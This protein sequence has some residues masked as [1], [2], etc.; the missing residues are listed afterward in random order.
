MRELKFRVWDSTDKVMDYEPYFTT[1]SL[2]ANFN[3]TNLIFM[4]WTGLTDRQGVEIYEGDIVNDND[5]YWYVVEYLAGSFCGKPVH[6]PG[7]RGRTRTDKK[8][9]GYLPAMMEVIG[10]IYQNPELLK[11]QL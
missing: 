9:L 10:N 1:G 4:Q 5:R 6:A 7:M 3:D 2:N 11:E 8:P